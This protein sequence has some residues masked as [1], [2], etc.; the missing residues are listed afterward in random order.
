MSKRSISRQCGFT[1][2]EL[3]IASAIALMILAGVSGLF[4][5]GIKSERTNATANE[6][7]M[8]GRYAIEVLRREIMGANFRGLSWADPSA[9]STTFAVSGDCAT[10]F[11]INLHQGLWAAN[12]T[13]PFSATCIP[14][15]DYSQGDV[16]VVRSVSSTKASTYPTTGTLVANTLYLRSAYEKS[17]IFKGSTTP[18]GTSAYSPLREPW[19]D[20]PLQLGVFHVR[21]Y[22][23]SASESPLVPALWRISLGNGPTLSSELVASN[24]E[25]FQ[26]QVALLTTDLNTQFYNPNTVSATATSTTTGYTEWDDVISVRI[27]V[28]MRASTPENGYTNTNTYNIGDKT[29]TVSDNYRREVFSTV[30]QLRNF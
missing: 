5:A 20:Y 15:A 10:D 22:T 28:L 8:N 25:D 17:E 24:V 11:T 23:V 1:I 21:P 27:W 14:T 13:N 4:I 29:T 12:D 18:S 6:L 30:V 19:F 2:V 9:P 3:M 26:I 7:T 16:L